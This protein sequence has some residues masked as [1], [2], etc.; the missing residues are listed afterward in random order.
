MLWHLFE[1]HLQTLFATADVFLEN[2]RRFGCSTWTFVT[3]AVNYHQ[4]LFWRFGL[5]LRISDIWGKIHIFLNKNIV[6]SKTI[7]E[8]VKPYRN[9]E[10]AWPITHRKHSFPSFGLV[11]FILEFSGKKPYFLNKKRVF[12]KTERHTVLSCGNSESAW[13]ITPR[14][15]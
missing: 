4:C 6:F 3:G 10:S 13:L 11:L 12:S 7:T 8:A 14:I 5:V 1:K 15:S 9:S 2:W